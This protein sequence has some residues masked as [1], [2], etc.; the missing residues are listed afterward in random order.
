M[1]VQEVMISTT[2]SKRGSLTTG[3]I[4]RLCLS[5]CS[6]GIKLAPAF[7]NRDAA[8]TPGPHTYSLPSKT[9][10]SPAKSIGAKLI[11]EHVSDSPGPGAYENDKPKHNDLKFS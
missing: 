4:Q 1:W 7:I 6:M 5:F 2:V 3:K 9:F 10:D 11:V 8:H